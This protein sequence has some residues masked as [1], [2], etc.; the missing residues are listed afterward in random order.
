MK[1]KKK[2]KLKAKYNDH[3]NITFITQQNVYIAQWLHMVV[4][5]LIKRIYL[6]PATHKVATC[7]CYVLINKEDLLIP[8]T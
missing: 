1:N 5:F 4:M 2:Y 7:T 3:K 8:R 6:S